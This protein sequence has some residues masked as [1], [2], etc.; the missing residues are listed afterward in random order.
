M[1]SL[2]GLR[3]WAALASSAFA[4]A[5]AAQPPPAQAPRTPR[6]AAQV[7]VTGNWVAQITEDWRWRMITPPK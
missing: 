6:A 5:A 1:E 7:D 3:A 2:R 4:L